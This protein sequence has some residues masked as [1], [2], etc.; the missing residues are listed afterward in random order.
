MGHEFRYR[1]T[2]LQYNIKQQP[3]VWKEKTCPEVVR[4]YWE[5]FAL[6]T[7]TNLMGIFSAHSS[8]HMYALH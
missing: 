2:M 5:P 4:T 8:F 6:H 1:D 7:V 3:S